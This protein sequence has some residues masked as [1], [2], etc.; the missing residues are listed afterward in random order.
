MQ[1]VQYLPDMDF[2]VTTGDLPR[3]LAGE[4]EDIDA[5]FISQ[6]T[7][8]SSD[9]HKYRHLHGYFSNRYI[10]ELYADFM[11]LLV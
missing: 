1:I 9:F 5:R 11:L 4:E 6:C 8:A 10:H 2:V 3:V 7:N